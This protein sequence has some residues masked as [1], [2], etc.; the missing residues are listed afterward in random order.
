MEKVDYKNTLNLP[1]TSFPM[2]ANLAQKEPEVIA[3]WDKKRIYAKLREKYSNNKKY[4]LHDGPPYANGHI[5][6]GTA[7]NK[8]LKDIVVKIKSMEGYNAV[9]VPGWDCH[10]L[11][12]E[13]EVDKRLGKN[14]SKLSVIEIRKL[15]QDYA[16]KFVEIQRNEFKRLE[17]LADWDNPY[18]TMNPDYCAAIIRELGKFF[19]KGGVYRR[20]KPIYW[21][22]SCRTALAEA[23]VEYEDHTSLSVYVKFPVIKEKSK[24]L[25]E[26]GT[27]KIFFLI[28]TTTPWTL[29]ANL[30]IALHPDF[31]YSAVEINGEV[32]IVARELVKDVIRKMGRIDY[33]TLGEY[34][35]VDLEGIKCKHP[36]YNRESIIILGDHVTLE[37]GTGCVH[38]AP[39]HGA[40]DYDMGIKY[41]LEIYN[42]VDDEGRFTKDV[43]EFSGMK[44]FEANYLI[45]DKLRELG[46]LSFEEKI[47]HSYPHCWRCKNPIIF[48]ATE[49]W[50]ISMEANNLRGKA[51]EEIKRVKW[52]PPWG[53]NRIT[54][55][56]ENR[57]DWCIS[58]QRS[59]GVPI[60]V[61]Y[62]TSCNEVLAAEEIFETVAQVVAREGTGAWFLKNPQDFLPPG[63]FCP[64]CKGK[65]FRKE[66]DILDVW[67]DSGTSHEAVL[68]R[69]KD[70]SWPADMYLEGSDQHRG[71]FNSSLLIATANRG[72]SPFREVLTHGYVV[73]GAG[74]KMAKSVGNVI[75]PQEIIKKYGAEILRLWASS[76]DY[77]E[78]IRISNEIIERLSE[79]YRKIRNTFKY[80]LG[81]LYDFD[82]EKDRVPYNEMEE[83][84]RWVLHHLQKLIER[85]RRAFD[86]YEFHIFFHMFHNFCSVQMSSFYLDII[87]DRLYTFK[88][89]SRERRSAQTALYLILRSLVKLMAPI[90]SF[91]AE[92]IWD[93]IQGGSTQEES[94]HLSLFPDIEMEYVD[95]E[96]AS[97]WDRIILL[98]EEVAKKLEKARREKLIG[99]SLDA[100]VEII[101]KGENFQFF[102]NYEREFQ[103]L[104]IVSKVVLR[105]EEIKKEVSSDGVLKGI[106]IVVSKAP[107]VKCERCWM[108]S[109]SVGSNKKHPTICG[110]CAGNL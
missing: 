68:A 38:T 91:T 13:H 105:E 78:D 103:A 62:C 17:I 95:E 56:I 98:R 50:F 34:K 3:K 43:E 55:M 61:F 11:P 110:R 21:C 54:G 25:K 53:E 92:E 37:Q 44:V 109:E 66:T 75:A 41:G 29:P 89:D 10:G 35:G 104:F 87:K 48:R 101:G 108:Y 39:G 5:H 83:L 49:Q 102:K 33:H 52:I 19:K 2:K 82:F 51:L 107:G 97:R 20:K 9:Y 64:K 71:W 57:P 88:P 72:S 69:R 28:W 4:I 93:Y 70:L 67:F 22:A 47:T 106:A 27:E 63:T 46:F 40:E 18:L 16:L 86:E 76:V 23:E 6:I 14:K 42:P 94:V 45:K 99:H 30:A 80:L 12:I 84:D 36:L 90:L 96:L 74:K 15:C 31:I 100:Q 58:R 65:S 59:W 32:L 85:V 8:I 79:A 26:L 7:L 81:N 77:R 60:T 24:F 1:R 73:D